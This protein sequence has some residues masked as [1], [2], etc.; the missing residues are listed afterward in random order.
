MCDA[1]WRGT[2]TYETTE[3]ELSER[4]WRIES[5]GACTQGFDTVSYHASIQSSGHFATII[6]YLSCSEHLCFLINFAYRLAKSEN[7]R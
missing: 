6:L 2:G 1:E 4:C 5:F 7:H 3:A